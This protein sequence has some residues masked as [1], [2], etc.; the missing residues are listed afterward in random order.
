M[1][2]TVGL[3]L[4]APLVLAATPLAAQ[5]HSGHA[6]HTGHEESSAQQTVQTTMDHSTMD[7]SE[8]DHSKMD[9][10]KMDHSTMDHSKM[11]HST[12]DHSKMDHSSHQVGDLPAGPPPQ[13]AFAGPQ[14]AADAI[15]GAEAMARSRARNH[16][17]HGDMKTGVIMV[18]RLEARVAKGH[19]AYL[20]DV[21]GWYGGDIDKFVF[22]SEGEGEFGGAVEDAELQALWGHAIGPFFDLQ[23]G[24]RLDV[25]PETRSHFVVGVQGLAPYMWHLDAAAFLSDRGDFTARVE[26]EYD[27]KITQRLILQPR[28]ELEISAQDI[29]ERKVGAGLTKLETGLRLRYEIVREFAP[30]VGVEYEAKLGETADIARAAGEDAAGWKFLVGLRAWF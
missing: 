2:T 18:E 15:F 10:S 13:E 12:M 11:D 5:D 3:I 8:M 22:K 9:H 30:Y 17:T 24:V 25:E 4:A 7:H 27:Q 29:P 20:W 23:T 19:D 21:Q 26:A 6:G 14:H 28:A 16:A 1:K